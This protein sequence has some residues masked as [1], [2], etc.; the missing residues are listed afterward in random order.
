[1]KCYFYGMLG[2]DTA[3]TDVWMMPWWPLQRWFPAVM[4]A[5]VNQKLAQGLEPRLS[6]MLGL[7]PR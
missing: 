5:P 2:R 4:M 1:M 3:R 7:R 6:V